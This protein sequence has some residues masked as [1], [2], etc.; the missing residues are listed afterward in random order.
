MKIIELPNTQHF[1]HTKLQK[2]LGSKILTT[3]KFENTTEIN[4]ES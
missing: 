1:T 4:S 2:K 3:Y